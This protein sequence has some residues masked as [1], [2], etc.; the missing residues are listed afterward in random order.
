M[1]DDQDLFELKIADGKA[2]YEQVTFPEPWSITVLTVALLTANPMR[3]KRPLRY[4]QGNRREVERQGSQVERVLWGIMDH[5]DAL[6]ASRGLYPFQYALA[7]FGALRGWIVIQAFHTG[8]EK[9]PFLLDYWDP[10]ECAC[11]YGADGV[12]LL[13]H[14]YDEKAGVVK[15][16]GRKLGWKWKRIAQEDDQVVKVRDIW[17]DTENALLVNG[18]VVKP[19]A[20]HGLSRCPIVMVP[21][22]GTPLVRAR[23]TD[24]KSRLNRRGMSVL[25]GAAE[26]IRYINR[27]GGQV[28]DGFAV[29]SNPVLIAKTQDGRHIAL[30]MRRGAVNPALLDLVV[31]IIRPPAMPGDLAQWMGIWR[32]EIQQASYPEVMYGNA[33]GPI[34][35]FMTSLLSTAGAM[36]AAPIAM[37]MR[38]GL[39]NAGELLLEGWNRFG[40]SIEVVGRKAGKLV[41]EEY[42][43]KIVAGDYRVDVEVEPALPQDELQNAQM[44]RMLVGSDVPLISPPTAQDK[45]LKIQDPEGENKRIIDS[46]VT[47]SGVAIGKLGETMVPVT[48]RLMLK[49]LVER[50][51]I[52]MATAQQIMLEMG[53]GQPPQPQVQPGMPAGMMPGG[54][55]QMPVSPGGPIP[56]ET[57]PQSMVP[58]MPGP[59]MTGVPPQV[60]P[61]AMMGMPP[62]TISPEEQLLRALLGGQGN[63]PRGPGIQR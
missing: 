18:E 44:A 25:Y 22:G 42:D 55:P 6:Q 54:V 47:M 13:V 46:A 49:A 7:Y 26:P 45:Y 34:S 48:M 3:W 24:L 32:S 53:V 60:M 8:D 19:L 5:A 29:W 35:G 36:R 4:G 59:E 43:P 63:P 51:A 31:D 14:A 33:P 17:T 41:Y 1:R 40:G 15:E 11:E 9:W 12:S 16:R 37:Q 56:P 30:D 23:N 27:L 38:A 62:P 52:D 2:G 61:Q 21:S 28:A 39:R 10:L 50:G 58:G 20:K 57:P